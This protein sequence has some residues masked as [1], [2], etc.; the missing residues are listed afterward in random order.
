MTEV[1]AAL[2]ER[3]RSNVL[4]IADYLERKK[5]SPS[6]YMLTVGIPYRKETEF[7]RL[8]AERN[9]EKGVPGYNE[10]KDE[11]NSTYDMYSGENLIAVASHQSKREG[12]EKFPEENTQAY[13]YLLKVMERLGKRIKQLIEFEGPGSVDKLALEHFKKRLQ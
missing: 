13:E 11:F 1:N 5:L 3:A 8:A 12:V 4:R 2:I 7:N 10:F 6:F 9:L